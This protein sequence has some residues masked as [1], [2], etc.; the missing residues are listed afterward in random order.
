MAS[1]L[2]TRQDDRERALNT[3]VA[4]IAE[5]WKLTNEEL[6]LILGLS[7]P[8]VSRLRAG[9][10]QL[11]TRSKSFEAGQYLLR[12]FRSLDALMGSDDQAS[13]SWLRTP[14][15]DLERAPVELLSTFTGL[16]RVCDYVDAFRARV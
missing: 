3:A 9:K 14:N 15:L 5:H 13:R 10:L 11:E 6:G 7:H 2:T 8:S 12:L 1:V 4:R 16:S